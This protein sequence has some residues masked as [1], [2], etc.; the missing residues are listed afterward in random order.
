MFRES[1]DAGPPRIHVISP[2]GPAT[3]P[4]NAASPKHS[5]KTIIQST[6]VSEPVKL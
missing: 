1:S 5:K 2:D 6:S 3:Y 4:T